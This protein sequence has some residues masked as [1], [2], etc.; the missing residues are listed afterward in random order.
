MG[1]ILYRCPPKGEP[2]MGVQGLRPSTWRSPTTTQPELALKLVLEGHEAIGHVWTC[3]EWA[4]ALYREWVKLRRTDPV[5]PQ[6]LE[7]TALW[8]QA[9]GEGHCG[10]SFTQAREA[11]RRG[12]M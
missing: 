8:S 9:V 11:A 5:I 10:L 12:P 6:T 3:E 4:A 1:V 7:L 2:P